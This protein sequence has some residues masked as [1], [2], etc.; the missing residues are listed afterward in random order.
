MKM[1]QEPF[2]FHLNPGCHFFYSI[3]Y[4]KNFIAFGIKLLQIDITG[5]RT[6]IVCWCFNYRDS[7]NMH[8]V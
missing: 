2:E 3:L 5:L 4:M 1:I 6:F 8:D 7:C